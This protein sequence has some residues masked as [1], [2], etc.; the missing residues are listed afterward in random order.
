MEK[1]KLVVITLLLGGW[2]VTEFSRAGLSLRCRFQ[3]R[4]VSR[5]RTHADDA[6]QA[7]HRLGY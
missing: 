5:A 4:G 3:R 2:L 1:W 6:G 7:C